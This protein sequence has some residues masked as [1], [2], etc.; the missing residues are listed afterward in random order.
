M[1]IHTVSQNGDF[2]RPKSFQEVESLVQRL[3]QPGTPQEVTRIQQTL[4]NIQRSPEG[5]AL[6][7]AL[8]QSHDEKVRFFGA[9]TFTIKINTDWNSLGR[10]TTALLVRLLT[11]L[12]QL[13]SGNEGALV[14][15]K[16]C[17]ALV[18]YF[19]QPAAAWTFCI[20]HILSCFQANSAVSEDS[21][22]QTQLSTEQIYQL[23]TSKVTTALWFAISLVE[24][25]GKIGFDSIQTHRP[26]ERVAANVADIIQLLTFALE[27]DISV[28]GVLVQEGVKCLQ[29]WVMYAHRAWS[30]KDDSLRSLQTLTPKV[31]SLAA[32]PDMF[33]VSQEFLTDVL[34]N[35]PLHLKPDDSTA[36]LRFLCSPAAEAYS[37]KLRN[38]DF[39]SEALEYG[40]LLLAF[41]DTH[42]QDL[43]RNDG[44]ALDT[45]VMDQL[46]G[47]LMCPGYAVV[48]DEICS[49]T[50]EFWI[51]YV[52]H[53]V[54]D[55][56]ERGKS[57][58]PWT[59]RPVQ[60][61]IKAIEAVWNKVRMPPA[62]EVSDSWDHDTKSNF[63]AFRADA[64]ELIH[65]SFALLGIGLFER[66]AQLAFDA[67][68]SGAWYH[69]EATLFCLNSL[70]EAVAENETGDEILLKLFNSDLFS[71]ITESAASLPIKTQKTTLD[72]IYMYTPFF[73]RH[74]G[75]LPQTL[76]FLFNCLA[77]SELANAAS[78][79]ILE[80]CDSC[81]LSL[82][83]ELGA[84]MQ[85]YEVL[86]SWDSVEP[87]AKERVMGA[88]A[89]IVQAMSPEEQK[90]EPLDQLLQFVQ[91]D[92]QSCLGSLNSGQLEDAK[93][94]GAH[95]LR[96]LSRIAKGMQVPD[97]VP[98]DLEAGNSAPTLWEKEQGRVMKHKI[99]QL[100]RAVFLP[101]RS[102]GEIVEA[103]CQILRDGY[104]ETIPGPFVLPLVATVDI[105]VK[106]DTNTPGLGYALD[107]A[108]IMLNRH[109]TEI[110]AEVSEAALGCFHHCLLLITATGGNP[111]N[112]PEA[113]RSCIDFAEKLI[114]SYLDTFFDPRLRSILPDFFVFTLQ[115]LTAAEIMPKR[116][117]AGFWASFVQVQE[118]PAHIQPLVDAVMEEYGPRL[119]YVLIKGIGG[120]A[121]RSELDTL[122]EPLKKLVLKQP[123][124]RR[125]LTDALASDTFPGK[126]VGD[127]EKRVWL[128]KV[129]KYVSSCAFSGAFD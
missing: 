53:L 45:C 115:C 5:W 123:K 7:D 4:Q 8:L 121:A 69:F 66:F 13:T 51:A 19:L 73:Q 70:A 118:Q 92:V 49:Q 47:L 127:T 40:R 25:A 62:Q 84:F 20:R 17:S 60:Y 31:I 82:I 98:I 80:T 2:D 14:V 46:V 58:P 119:A 126:S 9:L 116:S 67:L 91:R 61:L 36:L 37:S 117:A 42:L 35:Y 74:T 87:S 76:N 39:D 23:D 41:G 125:W 122:S 26:Q 55:M 52:E 38:G 101:L 89:S 33:D 86:R 81:R 100:Y 10:D 44:D 113:A 29:S 30:S 63:K 71:K 22:K 48:E 16:L 56:F 96:C 107:T 15:R 110:S 79:A 77:A 65:S 50:M 102:E 28:N 32:V 34:I 108:K 43:A 104:T 72:M 106:C 103:T 129:Y 95:A 88:I 105:I 75:Y 12:V 59:A 57:R 124:A 18:A 112:D 93:S 94:K 1:E 97:G 27:L 111:S 78:K 90:L 109:R 114:P 85:Q 6:A 21:V 11:W 54:D 99:V 83:G 120:E 24:E 68:A 128:Q 64:E 3:Y